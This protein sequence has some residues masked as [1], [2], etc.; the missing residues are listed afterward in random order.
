MEALLY[1]LLRTTDC[2][3]LLRLLLV[4]DFRTHVITTLPTSQG[5]ALETTDNENVLLKMNITGKAQLNNTI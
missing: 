5:V 4:L 2:L 1:L 3:F